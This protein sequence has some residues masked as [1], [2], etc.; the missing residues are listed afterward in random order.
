MTQ[1]NMRQI[2]QLLHAL[3]LSERVQI[4][5]NVFDSIIL[6]LFFFLNFIIIQLN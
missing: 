3:F 6:F 1:R 2:C 4:Y 5:V